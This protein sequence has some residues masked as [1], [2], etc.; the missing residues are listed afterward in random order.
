MLY[1]SFPFGS[2]P[3]FLFSVAMPLV[4]T[5]NQQTA[6]IEVSSLGGGYRGKT[7]ISC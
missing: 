1:G 3:L 5:F 7:R 2:D 6:K 4:F